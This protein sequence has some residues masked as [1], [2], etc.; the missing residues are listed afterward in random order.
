MRNEEMMSKQIVYAEIKIEIKANERD[1]NE[2][3]MALSDEVSKLEDLIREWIKSHK[4]SKLTYR[5]MGEWEDN[6]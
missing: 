1:I 4:S 6:K 3:E 2:N 5:I